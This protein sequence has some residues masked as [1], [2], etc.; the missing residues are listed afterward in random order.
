MTGLELKV[1]PQ[2]YQDMAGEQLRYIADTRNAEIERVI[3]ET[4][5]KLK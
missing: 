1:V 2:E 4:I 5:S 3:L